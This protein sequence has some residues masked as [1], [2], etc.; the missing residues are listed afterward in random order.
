[1]IGGP[2]GQQTVAELV[3]LMG[4]MDFEIFSLWCEPCLHLCDTGEQHVAP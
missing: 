3:E 1:M 4:L 2:E